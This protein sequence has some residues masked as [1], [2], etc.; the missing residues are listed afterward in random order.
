[1]VEFL[2]WDSESTISKLSLK[3]LIL[4]RIK[5]N[6]SSS[7]DNFERNWNEVFESNN[8]G[9][10]QLKWNFIIERTFIRPRD[11]I[12][13][14]NLALEQAKALLQANPDTIDKIT[15]DDIHKIRAKYSS[16]TINLDRK[17]EQPVRLSFHLVPK[18][19]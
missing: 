18:L 14:L 4:N 15:N 19:Q 6:I 16:I 7:S 8:I 17:A 3:S 13:L 9:K 11:I 2:D 12:K 5:N 10:N 1:M